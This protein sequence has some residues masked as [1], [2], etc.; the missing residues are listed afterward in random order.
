MLLAIAGIIAAILVLA[1][2]IGQTHG[3]EVG[4]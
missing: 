1:A 2:M 4:H 3:V